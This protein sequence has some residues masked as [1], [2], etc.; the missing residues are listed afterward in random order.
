MIANVAK[1]IAQSRRAKP[2]PD[3]SRITAAKVGLL[4]SG[5]TAVAWANANGESPALVSKVLSGKRSCVRGNSLRIAVKLGI[6]DP[7]PPA[8]TVVAR[9]RSITSQELSA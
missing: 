1:A 8:P 5:T 7:I 4:K 9:D 6:V 2:L 3:P